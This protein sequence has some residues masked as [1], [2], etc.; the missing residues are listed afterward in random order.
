[1][2]NAER[3]A[4]LDNDDAKVFYDY[5]TKESTTEEK[6]ELKNDLEFYKSHCPKK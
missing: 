2:K 6:E 4:I 3:V 1:M 5:A